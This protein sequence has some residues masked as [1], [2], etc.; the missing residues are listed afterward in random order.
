MDT[1][2]LS[3]REDSVIQLAADFCNRCSGCRPYPLHL[4]PP[5]LLTTDGN[6]EASVIEK[7]CPDGPRG[8][9]LR[10]KVGWGV[11]VLLKNI[12]YRRRRCGDV[13]PVRGIETQ[14]V[15]HVRRPILF[16]MRAGLK[17]IGVLNFGVGEDLVEPVRAVDK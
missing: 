8:R 11:K 2:R 3:Y 16:T 1:A 12:W 13:E 4:L 17:N 6:T 7:C 14:I 5:P 9:A 10:A 15:S